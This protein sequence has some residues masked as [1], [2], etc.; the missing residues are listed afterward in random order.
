MSA[1]KYPCIFSYQMEA[2]VY[3]PFQKLYLAVG[4]GETRGCLS[5]IFRRIPERYQDH[6]LWAWLEIFSPLRSTSSKTIHYHL[7]Y[8]FGS[9]P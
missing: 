6:V 4:G 3:L 2:T 1:D 9:M 8:F 5:E 7:S